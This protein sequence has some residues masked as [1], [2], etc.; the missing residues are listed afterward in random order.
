MCSYK[1]Q[2]CE[3]IR[4]IFSHFFIAG[5]HVPTNVIGQNTPDDEG[6]R[7]MVPR[8]NPVQ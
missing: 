2:L 1:G 3:G 6:E 7:V 8:I 5:V 4:F